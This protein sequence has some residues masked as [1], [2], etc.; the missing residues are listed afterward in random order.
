VFGLT[1]LSP[2]LLL[3]AVI[4]KLD[5]KGAVLFSQ[6]RITEGGRIFRIYKYRTM[7][8]EAEAETG[9]V[10]AQEN[11]SRCTR[12]G[13]F[14][15]MYN[16]DEL[17]QLINVLKGDMSLVGPRPE[18]PHFVDQF[19]DDIPRYMSRHHIKAGMTGWAQVNG[20][21]QGTPIEARVK[22]DLYYAENWSIWFDL[23]I[24]LMSLFALK[25][26]Y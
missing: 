8:P 9:P 20:L 24:I 1:A 14:L 11:D 2:L 3:I 22:Y 18:R 13:R 19:K 21:R 17:P 5:S 6:E 7:R 12:I 23:K 10:F 26:A 4:V 15:R 16:I 25:N